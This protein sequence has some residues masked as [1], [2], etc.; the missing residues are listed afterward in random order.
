MGQEKGL[1]QCKSHKLL[2]FDD[3]IYKRAACTLHHWIVCDINSNKMY[4]FD[5]CEKPTEA[6]LQIKC[7]NLQL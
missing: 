1:K 2:N 4:N 7:S 6:N 5:G 3:M